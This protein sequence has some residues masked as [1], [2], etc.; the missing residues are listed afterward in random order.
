MTTAYINKI[1]TAVP[2]NDV[3]TAFLTFALSQLG[4]DPRKVRAFQRMADRGGIDHRYSYFLPR[5]DLSNGALDH[6]GFYVRGQFPDTATRMRAFERL[7]PQLVIDAV[8]QLGLGP[9]R[10]TITHLLITCCTGFSAPGLDLEIVERCGLHPSVERSMI[11]FMGC[12][13]AMNAL[14]LARHIVRSEPKAR[15]LVVNL[16]LCTLHLKETDDM[17]QILSFMIFADGCAASL[18]SAEPAGIAMDRFHAVLVPD[19]SDLITWHIRESGFDMVLSGMVPSVI[20][21]ALAAET[22]A[23]LAGA[24][25]PS[26]DLWAVH[27]G[28]RSVLD[29][30][31]HA[32]RLGP[33][34]LTASRDVLRRFGNMSS[35]TVMFVLKSM[36]QAQPKQASGC[37]M[38]FGPGL[39]AETMLFHTGN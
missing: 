35:A 31:Q 12:Y 7:A 38:A 36:L 20:H 4:N 10:S 32:L 34:A 18:I 27:P 25:V 11:G 28:G 23:I 22:D 3:H 2:D 16:E 9:D 15:V 26:I 8:E 13:A 1:A 39:I 14:K 21:K 6:D 24:K 33:S 5:T 37:G 30:V 17:E 29:A 19:T